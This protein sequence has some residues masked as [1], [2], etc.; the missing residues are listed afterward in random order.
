MELVLFIERSVILILSIFS[1]PGQSTMFPYSIDIGAFKSMIL[2]PFDTFS[3]KLVV[4]ETSFVGDL[5]ILIDATFGFGYI[6][7]KVS[8]VVRPICKNESPAPFCFPMIEISDIEAT[9]LFEHSSKSMRASA[10]LNKSRIT[11]SSY[12]TYLS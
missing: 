4:S 5:F 9:I 6:A 11:L 2:S 3:I 8:F 7:M 10:L 12:P 1:L